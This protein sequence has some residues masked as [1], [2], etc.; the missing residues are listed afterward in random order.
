MVGL[1]DKTIANIRKHLDPIVIYLDMQIIMFIT[2]IFSDEELEDFLSIP[3]VYK[4]IADLLVINVQPLLYSQVNYEIPYG[5]FRIYTE[6]SFLELVAV[7][8]AA[9]YT[10]VDLESKATPTKLKNYYINKLKDKY[11]SADTIFYI[12]IDKEQP[13]FRLYFPPHKVFFNSGYIEKEHY[14]IF[15][16]SIGNITHYGPDLRNKVRAIIN[17]NNIKIT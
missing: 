11:P 13:S 12:K 1:L 14:E 9:G 8:L 10:S 2:D 3:E 4:D 7:L 17:D 6:Q 16:Q 5:Y 15:R